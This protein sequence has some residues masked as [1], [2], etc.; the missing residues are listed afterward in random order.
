MPRCETSHV[1]ADLQEGGLR[2]NLD[3]DRVAASRFGITPKTVDDALYDA[4]GQRQISTMFTELSQYRVVLGIL[5]DMD[6]LRW[7]FHRRPS[8]AGQPDRTGA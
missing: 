2:V 5:P 6:R 3:I 8:V 4:F 7:R 1:A